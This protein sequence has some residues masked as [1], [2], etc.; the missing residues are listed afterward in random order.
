[1]KPTSSSRQVCF[2]RG[3]ASD[4]RTA[5][6]D[7]EMHR[8]YVSRCAIKKT[9]CTLRV[10]VVPVGSEQRMQQHVMYGSGQRIEEPGA[11]RAAQPCV[12]G[13]AKRLRR[14]RGAGPG[15]GVASDARK[16]PPR[17]RGRKQDSDTRTHPC[18]RARAPH[19]SC[20]LQSWSTSSADRPRS[21]TQSAH[22]SIHIQAKHNCRIVGEVG[23]EENI[24]L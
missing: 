17:L 11:S 24:R 14:L 23:V 5:R 16:L 22:R 10:Q 7:W 3:G 1:M 9:A 13:G 8:G 4:L 6:V 21:A 18:T 12:S 20:R 15:G 19:G 2:W